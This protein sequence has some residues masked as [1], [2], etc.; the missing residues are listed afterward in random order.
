MDTIQLNQHPKCPSTASRDDLPRLS[1][2][3]YCESLEPRL[4]L[5]ANFSIA[6]V[7]LPQVRANPKSEFVDAGMDARFTAKVEG[8][9]KPTTQWLVRQPESSVF[10]PIKGANSTTYVVTKTSTAESGAQYEAVFVNS[11][12]STKTRPATL[13]VLPTV[14]TVAT[15][16]GTAVAHPEPSVVVS[17]STLYGT[18]AG[19]T[20]GEMI[21]FSVPTSGGP[22]DSI[23]SM[24]APNGGEICLAYGGALYGITFGGGASGQ[25]SVFSVPLTGGGPT[26]LASFDG[27]D[28]TS[29]EGLMMSGG[30][31]YGFTAKGGVYDGGTIFS[32]SVSGGSV[33]TLASIGATGE[34]DQTTSVVLAGGSFFAS[35]VSSVGDGKIFS[36]PLAGGTPDFLA[37]FAASAA[38][39]PTSIA[40]S[41]G[42]LFCS[43]TDGG[44][45][46]DGEVVSL[47][48]TGGRPTVLASTFGPQ[49]F[50]AAE[51]GDLLVANQ[52]LYGATT[53]G[54]GIVFSMPVSGG[55]PQVLADLGVQSQVPGLRYNSGTIFGLTYDGGVTG[56]GTVFKI[57][58]SL[59]SSSLSLSSG[60]DTADVGNSVTLT[61][62]ATSPDGAMPTG[63]V[64]IYDNGV[65]VGRPRPLID[66]VATFPHEKFPVGTNDLVATY[67]GDTNFVSCA[68]TTG[69]VT[70]VYSGPTINAKAAMV[71]TGSKVATL[72]VVGADTAAAGTAGLKYT[73]SAIHLPAGAKTPTFSRNRSN[74]ASR[75]TATFSKAGSYVLQCEARNAAGNAASVGIAVD[76]KQTATRLR[77]SPLHATVANGKSITIHATEL[78][79]FGHPLTDQ[80]SP[81]F[82]VVSGNDTINPGTGLFT[83]DTFGSAL[84][85]VEDA[86][87]SATLGLQ[88]IA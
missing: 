58:L 73:W 10:Q 67:S 1:A 50:G 24:D 65:L 59:K 26:V 75:I 16:N 83:A 51:P 5:S 84:I 6:A 23:G 74:A 69:L 86:D 15:L 9:P 64:E 22:I 71:S 76:V 21:I 77:L 49:G 79:Q 3:A 55:T 68:S 57:P 7:S 35:E 41:G 2:A 8:A 54:R 37:G 44:T 42:T 11:Q 29:P 25:G 34:S 62:T 70:R 38:F 48:T 27:A 28:G 19:A 82:A 12:G 45:G 60:Q 88:V 78:D 43:V 72:A 40:V 17:G 85:Q 31:L 39:V 13:T 52:I 53:F 20:S 33:S 63:T 47:P 46:G 80:A 36:V 18:S 30:V 66:G 32:L 81:T 87:L 4:A 56:D 14:S 61:A